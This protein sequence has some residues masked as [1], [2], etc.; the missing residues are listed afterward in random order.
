LP[1]TLKRPEASC[2]HC[3]SRLSFTYVVKNP[4]LPCKN[5]CESLCVNWSGKEGACKLRNKNDIAGAILAA[6]KL[7]DGM[8]RRRLKDFLSLTNTGYWYAFPCKCEM[9]AYSNS[10]DDKSIKIEQTFDTYEV[11]SGEQ[12]Q[13][14]WACKR[15][16][17]NFK[18]NV[19][20]GL[21]FAGAAGTGKNH[22]AMA[23]ESEVR[24]GGHNA[25]FVSAYTFLLE[26]EDA[27]FNRNTP[28]VAEVLAKF[29]HY[30]LLIINE[31]GR[32][33][34]D[35][36][37][38]NHMFQLLDTRYDSR[39]PTVLCGNVSQVDLKNVFGD[40]GMDRIRERNEV[41][42]FNWSSYRKKYE[43]EP[44]GEEDNEFP[45]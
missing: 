33:N 20:N 35:E 6:S 25:L 11:N 7:A 32:I 16:A 39:K 27:R 44:V 42:L 10:R 9:E 36:T 41:L 3:Q 28:S 21:V 13:V 26:I 17:I 43:P 19:G 31:I 37:S 2:R 4:K 45:F 24:K 5:C 38:R 40:A 29:Q 8:R 15:F 30:D 22:L 34:L 18:E 23:I 12:R 1:V 14:L